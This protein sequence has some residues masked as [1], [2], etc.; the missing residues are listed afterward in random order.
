MPVALIWMR[1][2][3]LLMERK[4]IVEQGYDQ[5]AECYADWSAQAWS[6]E[7]ARYTDLIV[8]KPARGR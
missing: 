8:Q 5:I 1:E 2:G 7:R 4:R 6:D 3:L